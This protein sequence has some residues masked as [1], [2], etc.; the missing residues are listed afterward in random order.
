MW[1]EYR[2]CYTQ[3]VL[4]DSLRIKTLEGDV[5]FDLPAGTQS[6]TVF[7]LK[8]KGI[9]VLNGKG[10]GDQL[11]KIIVDVPKHLNQRQKE[12]VAELEKELGVV[13]GAPV[14]NKRG[15]FDKFKG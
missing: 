6:G 3:A 2:V 11:V 13:R 8:G 14:N 9:Q 1:L 15:F 10:K 7:S 4:G 12:L 5:K